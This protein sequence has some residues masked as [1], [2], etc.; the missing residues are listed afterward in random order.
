MKQA[1]NRACVAASKIRQDVLRMV[2]Q[3]AALPPPPTR[4]SWLTVPAHHGFPSIS[5]TLPYSL[6]CFGFCSFPTTHT[7]CLLFHTHCPHIH[8][9]TPPHTSYLPPAASCLI[10]SLH[11]GL[12]ACLLDQYVS[13]AIPPLYHFTHHPSGL[14]RTRPF[15]LHLGRGANAFGQRSALKTWRLPG[16]TP[17]ARFYLRAHR[18]LRAPTTRRAVR[19]ISLFPQI[20]RAAL[21]QRQRRRRGRTAPLGSLSPGWRSFSR[22][23]PPLFFAR[24]PA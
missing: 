14:P 2:W 21:W 12:H 13:H 3:R 4:K 7:R 9:H 22:G 15:L 16:A 6:L 23:S 17:A 18:H 20:K 5:Q 1:S 8:T 19:L 24:M 10:L 11:L